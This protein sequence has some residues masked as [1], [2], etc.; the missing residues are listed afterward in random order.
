MS[1]KKRAAVWGRSEDLGLPVGPSAG[2]RYNVRTKDERP[3]NH[4]AKEK[5]I[6]RQTGAEAEQELENRP[7][8]ERERWVEIIKRSN[9]K[10]A[11]IN[12]NSAPYKLVELK[13]ICDAEEIDVLTLTETWFNGRSSDIMGYKCIVHDDRKDTEG[14]KW[15]VQPFMSKKTW[16]VW[17]KSY[18]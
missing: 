9:I 11:N 16:R 10:F 3:E 2:Q 15:G 6:R 4:R 18:I 12:I 13:S 5:G 14:G 1:R 17:Q 8:T 7:R